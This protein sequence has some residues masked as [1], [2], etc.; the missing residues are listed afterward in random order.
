M[1]NLSFCFKRK[2]E[3]WKTQNLLISP[4]DGR[5][6]RAQFW[7]ENQVITSGEVIGMVIPEDA[8]E[9]ICKAVADAQSIGKLKEGQRVLIKLDGFNSQEYGSV[10][11]V[12]SSISE[13]PYNGEY[14]VKINLINKL[15]TMDN[16]Q[17]PFIQDLTGT[18]EILIDES[19]LINKLIKFGN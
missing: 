19:R 11:G 16:I 1:K 9:I 13:I 8:I 2:I 17:I 7:S 15:T 14:Q 5:L 12:V 3:D 4:I 10:E 18:A 6:D